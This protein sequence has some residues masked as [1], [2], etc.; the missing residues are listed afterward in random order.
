MKEKIYN[1]IGICVINLAKVILLTMFIMVVSSVVFESEREDMFFDAM[2]IFH[3]LYEA[4]EEM[5]LE[6][7]GI[8]TEDD[9]DQWEW[10]E[11]IHEI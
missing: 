11:E 10:E 2:R 3:G 8:V 7:N 1:L 9:V 6:K 4:R 5:I